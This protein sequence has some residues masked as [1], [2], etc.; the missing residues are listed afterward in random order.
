LVENR[1]RGEIKCCVVASV[2]KKDLAHRAMEKKK[3]HDVD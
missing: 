1:D 3:K 2:I